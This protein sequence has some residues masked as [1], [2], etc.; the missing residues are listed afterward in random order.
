MKGSYI[1]TEVGVEQQRENVLMEMRSVEQVQTLGRENKRQMKF[2]GH[3][4][5]ALD[6]EKKRARF[7]EIQISKVPLRIVHY[8]FQFSLPHFL[9]EPR[10][11]TRHN[12]KQCRKQ[13]PKVGMSDQQ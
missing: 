2:L 11:V 9:K 6:R 13:A 1:D 4:E 12:A 7:L 5:D 3:E 10:L 8:S